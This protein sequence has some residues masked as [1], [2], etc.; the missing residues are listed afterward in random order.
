MEGI[1]CMSVGDIINKC[2]QDRRKLYSKEGLDGVSFDGD[3]ISLESWYHIELDRVATK[4]KL[5]HWLTHLI[6]KKWVTRKHLYWVID[7]ASE[8]FKY[9]PYDQGE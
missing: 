5:L 7:I 9:N 2:E 6:A 4:Q 3:T 1:T 8:H